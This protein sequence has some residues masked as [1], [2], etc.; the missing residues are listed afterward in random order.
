MTQDYVVAQS[1]RMGWMIQFIF[2]IIQNNTM[3]KSWRRG[4]GSN[5]LI[6]N[7]GMAC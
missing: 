4:M 2:G 1:I 3:G 7:S 5:K 6:P